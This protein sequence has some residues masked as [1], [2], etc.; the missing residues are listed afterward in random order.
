[1]SNNIPSH[2]FASEYCLVCAS[3][4]PIPIASLSPTL[5]RSSLLPLS[6]SLRIYFGLRLPLSHAHCFA[7]PHL[8]PLTSSPSLSFEPKYIL[9]CASPCPIPIA[10][11]SP[12]A[13]LSPSDFQ[14][15]SPSAFQPCSPQPLNPSALQGVNR[16]V[17]RPLGLSAPQTLSLSTS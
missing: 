4:C 15:L 5:S 11:L 6:L 2:S 12:T 16:S 17:S 7:Q 3:P 1:M 9:V 8:Q 13:P 14:P 10:S